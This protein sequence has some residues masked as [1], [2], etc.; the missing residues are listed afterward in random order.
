[1]AKLRR[2]AHRQL[3]LVAPH[4]SAQKLAHVVENTRISIGWKRVVDEAQEVNRE[5]DSIFACV[6]RALQ[7]LAPE[8]RHHADRAFAQWVLLCAQSQLFPI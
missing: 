4:G 6:G 8:A 3:V 5:T 7:L 2:E 1:M